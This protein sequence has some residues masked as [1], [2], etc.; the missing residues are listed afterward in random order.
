MSRVWFLKQ[1]ARHGSVEAQAAAQVMD[2]ESDADALGQ[3]YT[4][5]KP[6]ARRKSF[7]VLH[8]WRMSN[9]QEWNNDSK[10]CKEKQCW[11]KSI[12][13]IE[14][15]NKTHTHTLPMTPLILASYLNWFILPWSRVLC[16]PCILLPFLH[17]K[18]SLALSALHR[19]ICFS[20]CGTFMSCDCQCT[21]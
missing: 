6:V 12:S 19:W 20:A 11:R 16:M 9:F 14:K 17:Q 3:V 10:Q 5:L 21:V 13:L 8:P 2:M 7:P 4:N 15:G 18:S 1:H